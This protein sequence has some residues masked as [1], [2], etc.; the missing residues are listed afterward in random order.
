MAK[1]L[2]IGL[3]SGT[4]M[5]AVDAVLIDF[6]SDKKS[7]FKLITTYSEPISTP[8]KQALIK[9]CKP[10]QNAINRMGRA[11]IELGRL[12]AHSCLQLLK[13]ANVDAKEIRAIGSHGQTIRHAPNTNYPFTL[14]IGDPNII[15]AMTGITT[16]A[17]F[18][19][20][21]MALGGQ[22]AP[23]APAFHNFILRNPNENRWVLNIGGIAN[24]TYLAAD[25]KTP[26]LGFD[27]GPGNTLSDVWCSTHLGKS[28]DDAGQWAS[29]GQINPELLTVLL[30]D[31]YFQ[32]A[33]PKSTGREY[34]NLHWLQQQLY[35]L[36]SRP[37]PIDIQATLLELTARSIANAIHSI[38]TAPGS[39]WICGGGTHNQKLMTRL[40]ELCEK[41]RITTTE[42]IGVHPDWVEAMCFAW[43][44]QQTLKGLPGNLPSVTGAKQPTILGA[45]YPANT[46]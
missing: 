40:N 41:H 5:D 39:I 35:G 7:P 37:S 46:F 43:L 11:D 25:K 34:F 24:L 31:A 8:L 20:R 3:L 29:S 17:D 26:V 10:G 27:T 9:L 45:I 13:K 22:A 23:L 2:Y 16:V 21:D 36:A 30:S 32:V 6:S 1:E 14:Q 12:F 28:Y 15:A 33:P 38:E 19:R 4:S 42:E 18:R 44:A